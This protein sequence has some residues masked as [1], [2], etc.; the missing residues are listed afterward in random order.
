MIRKL[1]P[2]GKA[3]ACSFSYDDGVLQDIRFVQLLNKYGMKGTFNLNSQLMRQEF[4][5]THDTGM[6]VRRLSEAAASGLYDG[7]EVA[8]HTLT[9]PYMHD[10]NRSQIM[11]QMVQ[12]KEN[13]ENLFGT[14]IYGFAVPFTYYSDLI[15]S[16][17]KDAG[18]EY[19]RISEVTNSYLISP[20]PY[21]WRGGKF[22]WDGDLE[23]YVRSFL[24]TNH[25]LALCQIVGHSYDLD[26]M[27][28]WDKFERILYDLSQESDVLAMTN[29]E[30]VR[31]CRAMEQAQILPDRILNPSTIPLWFRVDHDVV[32]IDPGCCYWL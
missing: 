27:D 31:Y 11:E 29:I 18:F 16:C 8:S 1:F 25:E 12:D 4:A 3:K 10:L 15:A 21:Y 24:I 26:A 22:H 6:T 13:L 32:R 5:W 2:E 14:G 23:Q 28:L 30:L 7:H 9:H 17:A 20:N 19:V